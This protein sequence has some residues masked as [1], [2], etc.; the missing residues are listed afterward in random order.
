MR[1]IPLLSILLFFLIYSCADREIIPNEIVTTVEASFT[2]AN[3][4]C[5]APCELQFN[6]TSQGANSFLWRFGDGGASELENPAHRYDNGGTYN[7][8]LTVTGQNSATDDTTV[9][10]FIQEPAPDAVVA[11]FSVSDDSCLAPCIVS[12]DASNSQNAD[13][14]SWDFGD[15]NTASGETTTHQ[16]ENAGIYEVTLIA[17]GGSGKDTSTQNISI[18]I[19]TTPIS[20]LKA[21]FTID[22]ISNGGFAPATVFVTNCSVGAIS[23]AWLWGDGFTGSTQQDPG[24]H[25]YDVPGEFEISLTVRDG[26]GNT[27]D[28]VMVVNISDVLTFNKTYGGS[29]EDHVERIIQTNDGGYALFGQTESKGNGGTDFWMIRTD[30]T[31]EVVWEKTFGGSS[32]DDGEFIIE[33]TDGSFFLSGETRSKGAGRGDFWV[34]KTDPDGNV[35]WDRTFGGEENE[36]PR[37]MIRAT[38]G[39]FAIIGNTTANDVSDIWLVRISNLGNII[40]SEMYGRAGFDAAGS[41]TESANEGFVLSGSS[42]A[43][44]PERTSGWLIRVGS[45]G[46]TVWSNFYGDRGNDRFITHISTE[47]GGIAA[48]GS[49]GEVGSSEA[50]IW[51]VRTDGEGSLLWEKRYGGSEREFGNSLIQLEDGGFVLVGGTRSKGNGSNDVW[52]IRTDANGEIIWDKT[53]GGVENDFAEDV[54]R[55]ADGGLAIAGDTETN[56]AG[57][58]DFW[59]IKTDAEGNVE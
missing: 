8:T 32:D 31:G 52:V 59:F 42:T 55:T 58:A 54:I 14:F 51:L 2:V 7:V 46:D 15:G 47:D 19:D 3:D 27:D 23:Y 41:V 22:S 45:S 13:S 16:Y 6:S 53:Y 37:S 9:A 10:V 24:S 56:S 50:D 48:I 30:V 44:A 43:L 1:L 38:D 11:R 34:I 5:T 39:G 18:L 33:D 12:F 35:I 49:S 40:W 21:C 29:E 4:S 25:E 36:I 28:T 26:D 17:E 20:T 57:S